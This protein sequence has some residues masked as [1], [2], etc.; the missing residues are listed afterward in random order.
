MGPEF[1]LRH[2]GPAFATG[3]DL[4]CKP[5]FDLSNNSFLSM[6][7]PPVLDVMGPSFRPCGYSA[8]ARFKFN[9][10]GDRIAGRKRCLQRLVKQFIKMCRRGCRTFLRFFLSEHTVGALFRI[11]SP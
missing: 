5:Y 1:A 11:L 10:D 6:A 7:R 2:D 4:G 8:L 9:I 3:A